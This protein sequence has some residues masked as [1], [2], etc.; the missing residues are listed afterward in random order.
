MALSFRSTQIRRE[1]CG[2]DMT[3]W[4]QRTLLR[5]IG[6][7]CT[8]VT[9]A[10]MISKSET[11]RT[12]ARRHMLKYIFWWKCK[13]DAAVDWMG[14]CRPAGVPLCYKLVCMTRDCLDLQ[15]IPHRGT[16]MRDEHDDPF[17]QAM[18]PGYALAPEC[19][20]CTSPCEWRAVDAIVSCSDNGWLNSE[21]FPYVDDI[22][23]GSVEWALR[24]HHSQVDMEELLE[25]RTNGKRIRNIHLRRTMLVPARAWQFYGDDLLIEILVRGGIVRFNYLN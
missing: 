19:Y 21:P 17:F 2:R 16:P 11:L 5:T 25:L 14:R 18:I 23:K 3:Y 9:L 15:N 4:I 6:A 1:R 7:H 20:N 10:A 12:I 13:K 22:I 8:K 24:T